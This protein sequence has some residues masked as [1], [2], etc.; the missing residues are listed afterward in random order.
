MLISKALLGRAQCPTRCRH[1]TCHWSGPLARRRAASSWTSCTTLGSS[2][3]DQIE[4][5]ISIVTEEIDVVS[6]VLMAR[7]EERE[8]IERVGRFVA[9]DE[10]ASLL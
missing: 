10:L 6:R 7:I 1:L 2:R 4:R 9:F 8:H 3:P 5:V